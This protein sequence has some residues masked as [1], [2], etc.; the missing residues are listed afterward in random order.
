MPQ[1]DLGSQGSGGEPG[2]QYTTTGHS[3]LLLGLL[4][5][6]QVSVLGRDT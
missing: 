3:T 2:K 4:T 1:E 6:L 5:R